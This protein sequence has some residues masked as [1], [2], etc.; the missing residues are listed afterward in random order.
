VTQLTQQFQAPVV[1][2]DLRHRD[3]YA[4]RLRGITTVAAPDAVN[5]N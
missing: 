4:L 3:G 1:Y 5:R 2:A